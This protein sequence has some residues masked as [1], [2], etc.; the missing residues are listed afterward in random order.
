MNEEINRSDMAIW[1][2]IQSLMNLKTEVNKNASKELHN[3]QQQLL[4]TNQ[5]INKIIEE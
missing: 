4:E 5:W 1:E 3:L 2:T